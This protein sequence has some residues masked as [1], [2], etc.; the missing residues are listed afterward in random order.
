MKYSERILNMT[1]STTMA[2][3]AKITKLKEEG[4]EVIGFGA[5]EPDFNTP[6]NIIDAAIKAMHEGKTKYTPASG[7]TPLKEAIIR[8]FKEDNDLSYELSQISI[9]T[10]AKQC[11]SNAFQAVLNDGDEVLMAV[12]YWVTYPELLK[13]YGGVPVFCHSTPEKNY[14]LDAQLLEQYVTPKSKVLILNSPNNPTG[15]VYTKEELVEL[16]EFAKKHDLLIIAD[17]MYEKLIYG[18]TPHVSIGALSEDAYMRT[19]TINGVSKAYAMTG[20]RIG[21]AAG[22]KEIIKLMNSIQGHTTSNPCSISQYASVEA[23]NGDQSSVNAMKAEF[24]KRRDLM[25]DLIRAIPGLSCIKPDGAFYI[26]L[27]L[28]DILGKSHK[29]FKIAT[30]LDFADRLLSE[31]LVAVVPGEG[32]GI[33]GFA[34][35]SYATSQ[36]NIRKGMNLISEFVSELE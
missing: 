13:M 29:G 7:I 27:K 34:R 3:T 24:E 18:A 17:E 23:I 6:L 35:M 14:K 36:E 4:K 8:K 31:K 28:R 30:A 33:E 10:G 21:Y 12:P 2:I 5:G 15:T 11:L 1:P 16:A 25:V 20:W 9:S 22:P 26:M 32:F 19:I